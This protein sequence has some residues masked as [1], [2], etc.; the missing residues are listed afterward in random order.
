MNM[1]R[2]LEVDCRVALAAAW[3]EPLKIGLQALAAQAPL[4]SDSGRRQQRALRAQAM[5]YLAFAWTHASRRDPWRQGDGK[6]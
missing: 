3:R 1:A 4:G 6:D 5:V 2:Q